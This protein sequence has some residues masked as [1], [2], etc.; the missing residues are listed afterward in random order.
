MRES[1]TN[2]ELK[3]TY[4]KLGKIIN[5]YYPIG[6]KNEDPSYNEY[7]GILS[8]KGKIENNILNNEVFI[9]KWDKDFFGELEKRINCKVVGATLGLVPNVGGF[10]ELYQSEDLRYYHQLHFYVSLINNYFSIQFAKTDKYMVYSNGNI[11]WGIEELVVSP[12]DGYYKKLFLEIENYIRESFPNA[13]YLPY[14]IDRLKLNGLQVTYSILENCE[15]GRAFF[16]KF[17]PDL[18]EPKKIIGDINYR[19]NELD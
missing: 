1:I 2:N 19:I 9:S 6:I 7:I 12:V 8:L 15:I 5:Y 17:L 14:S 3:K 11:G 18:N 16:H 10:I 4:P 13:K